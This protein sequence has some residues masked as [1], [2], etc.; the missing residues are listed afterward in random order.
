M[1]NKLINMLGNSWLAAETL[2]TKLMQEQASPTTPLR[3]WSWAM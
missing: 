2:T 1:E 3:C